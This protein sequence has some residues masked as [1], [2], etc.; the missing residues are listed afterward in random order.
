MS[1]VLSY[2]E[3]VLCVS[4]FWSILKPQL[5]YI[6]GVAFT[7]SFW[8]DFFRKLSRQQWGRQATLAKCRGHSLRMCERVSLDDRV[9][10]SLLFSVVRWKFLNIATYSLSSLVCQNEE[11]SLSF[12]V[13]SYFQVGELSFR[14]LLK[15]FTGLWPSFIPPFDRNLTQL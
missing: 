14:P 13:A 10:V 3:A 15:C 11:I 1:S 4:N 12:L 5:L 9:V 8:R 2:E 6:L 7:I